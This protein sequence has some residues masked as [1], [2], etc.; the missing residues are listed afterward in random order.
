MSN[1]YKSARRQTKLE[2]FM[3]SI[4]LTEALL[5][6]C[7]NSNVIPKSYR[8]DLSSRILNVAFKLYEDVYSANSIYPKGIDTIKMR[9]KFQKDAIGVITYKDASVS[10]NS[11]MGYAKHKTCYRTRMSIKNLF[12]ELFICPKLE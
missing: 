2:V 7:H 4:D 5:S 1:V 10:Y 12:Y 11:W 3:C 8:Y 6:A 9:S